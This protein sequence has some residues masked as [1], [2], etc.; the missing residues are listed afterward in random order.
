VCIE[1][2]LSASKGGGNE[3]GREGGREGGIYICIEREREG[4]NAGRNRE[5]MREYGME[6]VDHDVKR[7]KDK[8][9]ATQIMLRTQGEGTHTREAGCGGTRKRGEEINLIKGQHSR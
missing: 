1:Q 6:T 8:D 4:E 5:E 7:N 2:T 3:G 9:A